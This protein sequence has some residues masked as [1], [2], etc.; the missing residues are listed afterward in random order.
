MGLK[1]LKVLAPLAPAA[2]AAKLNEAADV[3]YGVNFNFQSNIYELRN[4]EKRLGSALNNYNDWADDLL[5]PF[6]AK[7]ACRGSVQVITRFKIY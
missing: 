5:A 3:H 7:G 1:P 6:G 4:E 2:F